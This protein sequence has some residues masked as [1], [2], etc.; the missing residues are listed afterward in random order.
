MTLF[1]IERSTVNVLYFNNKYTFS[2]ENW[3]KTVMDLFGIDGVTFIKKNAK[4]KKVECFVRKLLNK[5]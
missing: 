3:E 4:R 1:H 2:F 5:Y